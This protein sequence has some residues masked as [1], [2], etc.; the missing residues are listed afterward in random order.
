[1]PMLDKMQMRRRKV[2]IAIASS[3]VV[4]GISGC[5]GRP[6]HSTAFPAAVDQGAAAVADARAKQD[7]QI[8]FLEDRAAGDPLDVFSLNGLAVD[9]LQRARET[10]DVAE[11][12]RAEDVLQ[13]SLKVRLK[14]NY[15]GIILLANVA[16]TK[17]DFAKGLALAQAAIPQKPKEA[18]GYGVLGDSYMGLGRYADAADA[19]DKTIN[20]SA[21][22]TAF[23]RRALL[24][25]AR[26]DL[27]DAEQSWQEAIKRADGDGTPEHSAWANAQIANF[28]FSTGRID[29]ARSHY[30]QSLAIFP[31]YV[32]AL[33]G[34]GRVAAAD[35]DMPR[36]IDYYTRAI[37]TVPLPEYVIAL[38]DVYAAAGDA[39]NAQAQYDL[40]GAIE[41]L[42]AANGVNL[43][44]QIGLFNADHDRNVP[45]TVDRAKAAYV[46][47]S[48]IQA[49]DALAWV[50]YKAGNI[51]EARTA[52]EAALRVGTRDPLIAFHAA[53]ILRASGDEQ[54]ARM[55]L[56]HVVDHTPHFSVLYE[57]AAKAMLDELNVHAASDASVVR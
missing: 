5:G 45:A 10:G 24:F 28:Y 12:S 30:E 55:Y 18:Y 14:D 40:V 44:L 34:I 27:D 19:Y 39:K 23:G 52:I 47:Q 37:N 51:S 41:Q 49:A 13:R 11:L 26:G 20:L 8:K 1:M 4:I 21:D 33:A 15:E 32:H 31:G 43:D 50:Q 25:Q 48:S 3:I 46:Q 2:L 38:G 57:G 16:N 7:A 36:A 56:E 29:D 42:Y 9:H 6:S 17:H 54:N 53:S 35:G 22:L